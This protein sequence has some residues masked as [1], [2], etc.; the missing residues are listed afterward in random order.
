MPLTLPNPINLSGTILTG[1]SS[2]LLAP[3]NANRTKFFLV[4]VDPTNDLWFSPL[5]PAGPNLAG[6]VRIFP[7]GGAIGFNGDAP[8]TAYYI[9]GGITGQQFTAWVDV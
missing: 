4:N 9:Y 6:S 5:G 2:Q 3:A 7:N 1:G 8:G